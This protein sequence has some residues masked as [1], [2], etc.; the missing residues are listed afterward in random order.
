MF[1][2]EEDNRK[3]GRYLSERI[4]EKGF[5]SNRDFVRAY[6]DKT[7]VPT[8]GEEEQRM[9]N[10]LSQMLN[11]NKGIQ[12]YDLPVFT[13]LLGISCE[14]LLSAGRCFAASV[15]HLTN[16]SVALSDDESV[17]KA[18]AEEPDEPILNLDEYGKNI[19]EYALDFENYRL[20]SYLTKEGYIYFVGPDEKDYACNFGAGVK[21]KRLSDS[22]PRDLLIC[23]MGEDQSLRL[24][25]LALAAERGDL[26]MLAK[27]H[28]REIPAF[29]QASAKGWTTP[30]E[31]ESQMQ[32]RGNEEL[33]KAKQLAEENLLD[34]VAAAFEKL[35]AYFAEEFEVKNSFGEVHRFMYPRLPELAARLLE[36]KEEEG[37]RVLLK[38]A[39]EHNRNTYENLQ[40]LMCG[41]IEA[42]QKRRPFWAGEREKYDAYVSAQILSEFKCGDGYVLYRDPGAKA[43]LVTNLFRM[44]EDVAADGGTERL[45][46]E[47]NGWYD[48]VC[49]IRPDIE[50]G[51]AE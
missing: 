48:R 7:G 6:L 4:K 13:E 33:R 47:L 15:N 31:A 49:G 3:I 51:T 32:M 26:D 36:K 22:Q 19:I 25:L 43:G 42:F 34:S 45:I 44:P 10:R 20:L 1:S 46:A 39:V 38:S 5:K 17:W 11:G 23:R 2:L 9:A 41:T 14:E 18:Y 28:A 29:Y 8:G 27:L 24:R 35:P 21:I 40:K 30:A 16:Y 37:A 12:I 50:R